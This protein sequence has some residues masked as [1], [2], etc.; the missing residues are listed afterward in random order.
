MSEAKSAKEQSDTGEWRAH[1]SI[2]QLKSSSAMRAYRKEW[3]TKTRERISRGEP[4]AICDEGEVE[5]I[6]TVMDIPVIGKHWWAGIIAA[7]QM[8]PYYFNLLDEKGYDVCRYCALG[9][10]CT[11]DRDPERAPWG[12][13]P[14]PTVIIGGQIPA[15]ECDSIQKI[16]EIWAREYNAYSFPLEVTYPTRLYPRWW[17]RIK[18]HWNEIIEPHRLDLRVEE[19]RG[20]IR[21]LEIT[22]G[23]T[24]SMAKFREV[25][26][27]VNEQNGYFRKARDLMAETVP[28]PVGL[29]DQVSIY[30]AQ[31]HRGTQ[32]GLDLTRMFYEEVKERVAKSEAAC[33]NEKLR[34]MWIGVGLWHNTAFYQYFEEKYGAVFTCSLYLAIAADGYQRNLFNDPLR[35]LASR[36]VFLGLGGSDWQVKE[37]KL[38]KVNGVV[39]LVAKNCR[40][41]IGA[42]L[43]R[44]ALENAGIPVLP[45]YT[46]NVDAREW[47]DDLIKSQ[48]S[49]F[50]ETRLLS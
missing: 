48:V 37:A 42:P 27:L 11:L 31:W 18:D 38:N 33:P 23:K 25:M 43:I 16:T 6:F 1:R 45:I 30:P 35:A 21:F 29:L 12:G 41:S 44:I 50:I 49:N 9:L 3:F 28:C 5:E 40:E 7:K 26:E 47:D 17:E 20:L 13:L 4:L 8:A 39:Q 19:L 36:S 34:L 15:C 10:G 14:K 22:T 46:D 32:A 2:K 24:F